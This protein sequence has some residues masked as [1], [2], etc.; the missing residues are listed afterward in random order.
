MCMRRVVILLETAK[1]P[2]GA[3]GSSLKI[4]IR[5]YVI[6]IDESCLPAHITR[7]TSKYTIFITAGSKDEIY[8]RPPFI[9][10]TNSWVPFLISV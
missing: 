5:E 6:Y 10:G 8:I 3:F 7:I 2:L 1:S 4:L 9:L